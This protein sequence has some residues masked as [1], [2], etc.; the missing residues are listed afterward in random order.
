[1]VFGGKKE[2]TNL[3]CRV[4]SGMVGSRLE[5]GDDDGLGLSYAG[6]QTPGM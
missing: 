1:M 6:F 3:V 4:C 2:E 5:F